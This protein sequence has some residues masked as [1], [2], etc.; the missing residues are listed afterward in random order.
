MDYT[1]NVTVP[2]RPGADNEAI[3]DARVAG[4]TAVLQVELSSVTFDDGS[5]QWFSA[6]DGCRF[7]P[8][9]LMLIADR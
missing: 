7:T 6:A 4:L 2:L 1:R 3:G 5:M 9:H 8:D